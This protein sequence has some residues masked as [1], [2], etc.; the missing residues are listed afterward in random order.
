LGFGLR[1]VGQRDLVDG[2]D[3]LRRAQ[4]G[5]HQPALLDL[6]GAGALARAHHQAADG[7][8]VLL[9]HGGA[10]DGICFDAGLA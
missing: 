8:H 3:L 4:R 5:E 6:D 2:A 9:G 7:H 10:D 1:Q